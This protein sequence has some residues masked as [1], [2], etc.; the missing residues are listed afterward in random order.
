MITRL[1]IG[2]GSCEVIHQTAE[3]RSQLQTSRKKRSWT[4][5]QTVAMRRCRNRSKDLIHGGRWWRWW[6]WCS[7]LYQYVYRSLP[8]DYPATTF[9]TLMSPFTPKVNMFRA[10]LT[11]L[12]RTWM[13]S[14]FNFICT[15]CLTIIGSSQFTQPQ[16]GCPSLHL[17]TIA[18][19][20]VK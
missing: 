3:T 2:C 8:V 18:S 13:I 5:Q 14:G 10:L 1:Y 12:R 9:R 19:F 11:R 20:C 17:T 7:E 16:T 6:L 15:I 4:L